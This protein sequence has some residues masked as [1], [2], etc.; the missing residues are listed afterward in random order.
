M[1]S[2]AALLDTLNAATPERRPAIAQ[3]VVDTFQRHKVVL[4]LDMSGFTL[5]VRR[6]GILAY[7]CQIRR[8]HLLT[9]PLVLAHGGSVVKNEADNLLAVFDDP[10]QAV[11]AA[12][13]M[14][15]AA[16]ATVEGNAA[17][18]AFSI[19]IDQGDILLIE[20]V[21]CF[22][23]AVNLAFKLGEDI[24]RAGEILVT[25]R[26]RAAV[27]AATGSDQGAMP[28]FAEMAVSVSGLPVLAYT[29]S[30]AGA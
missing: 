6:E 11:N 13:A 14:M 21:D 30:R 20:Q 10:T 23:D 9:R 22:G 8:M 26:V 18:I 29:V 27:M 5:T 12:L 15:D 28:L 16:A 7:L 1:Q 3:L 25:E 24:A 2:F 17:A 19:G 4:A